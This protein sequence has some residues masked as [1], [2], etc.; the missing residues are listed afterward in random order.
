MNWFRTRRFF[1]YSFG[2]GI[3]PVLVGTVIIAFQTGRVAGVIS[4]IAIAAWAIDS[5]STTCRRCAFYGTGRCG[6]P[7][8][9]VPLLFAK[10]SAFSISVLRIRLHYY[11]DLAMIGYVNY[12]Y[13]QVPTLFPFV[14]VGSLT[15]WLIVFRPKKFHGLLFRLRPGE[16]RA[17]IK[18]HKA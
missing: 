14:F 17:V 15:G 13:W 9:V 11:A 18:I 6:L 12:V 7:G 3:P 16:K 2:I 8:L 10:E 1:S 5:L 4:L